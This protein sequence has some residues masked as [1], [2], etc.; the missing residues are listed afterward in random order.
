MATLTITW[1]KDR[2]YVS[3]KGRTITV[4]FSSSESIDILTAP[5][6]PVVDG[7]RVES[8]FHLQKRTGEDPN[9]EWEDVYPSLENKWKFKIKARS[10]NT[11]GYILAS[12][13]D[14]S[15]T[16]YKGTYRFIFKENIF[17]ADQGPSGD[18]ISQS[19][20]LIGRA[21]ALDK[22][23]YMTGL[24]NNTI[25][26]LNRYSGE[27]ERL[28]N[29]TD[30]KSDNDETPGQIFPQDLQLIDTVDGSEQGIFMLG[31]CPPGLF[32][33][34]YLE[35]SGVRGKANRIKN[36]PSNFG[37]DIDPSD[38]NVIK[39]FTTSES[40]I[41]IAVYDTLYILDPD[42]M[43]AQEYSTLFSPTNA[44]AYGSFDQFSE[45]RLWNL[46]Q[47]LLTLVDLET[48]LLEFN[49]IK[50]KNLRNVDDM[51]FFQNRLY[52]LKSAEGLYEIKW[53][54]NTEKLINDFY[55]KIVT[56]E[57]ED[58]KEERDVRGMATDGEFLY[59]VGGRTKA[60]YRID[61]EDNSDNFG[62]AIKI[63]DL[64]LEK[65]GESKVG[66]IF[67]FQNNLYL[68][69]L[70][71]GKIFRV[72]I[73][74]GNLIQTESLGFGGTNIVLSGLTE[75]NGQLYACG[76]AG[77]IASIFEIDKLT[78]IAT[79]KIGTSDLTFSRDFGPVKE[80]FPTALAYAP[81]AIE[82]PSRC[83]MTG[84][85]PG[86]RIREAALYTVNLS[87]G[88]ATRVGSE[89]IVNFGVREFSP[90][91]LAFVP[92]DTSLL[93]GDLYMVGGATSK[94]YTIDINPES[95][96]YGTAK[97]VNNTISGF[98]VGEFSPQGL[99]Y[100]ENK[101]RVSFGS[102]EE[103]SGSIA[104]DRV[105]GK[106]EPVV[107]KSPFFLDIT[108]SSDI[109]ESDFGGD[110]ITFSPS[111]GHSAE[112]E[113]VGTEGTF[114]Q[115][116]I[117]IDLGWWDKDLK[118]G[119]GN[120]SILI[121]LPSLKGKGE[122]TKSPQIA[123]RIQ[124]DLDCPTYDNDSWEIYTDK[125]QWEKIAGQQNIL[126]PSLVRVKLKNSINTP[127]IED[128]FTEKVVGG[129]Q[130]KNSYNILS[131]VAV[132]DGVNEKWIRLKAELPSGEIG[133]MRIGTK[134]DTSVNSRGVLGPVLG[135]F[136]PYFAFDTT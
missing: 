58:E 48:G 57:G 74:T 94:L 50:V 109:D 130:T 84:T 19:F 120:G 23:L 117:R 111:D 92:N 30:F 100:V 22:S 131:V 20:N 80:K 73:E 122:L 105:Y 82:A 53:D 127:S 61:L 97:V 77:D 112:V 38:R 11:E 15:N 12:P 47:G 40:T 3:Q 89:S 76:L 28:S 98:G 115:F 18:I 9:F 14:E 10:G 135:T 121:I 88:V 66:K 26:S 42:S 29:V 16:G 126:S 114:Y 59:V 132:E 93:G 83:F 46:S 24:S 35:Q 103:F 113:N 90:A 72:N 2:S 27:A 56:R 37:L 104:P 95:E 4:F 78:G 70:M 128:F 62:K 106:I 124:I 1:D 63:T 17:G 5:D 32:S 33:V 69:G 134:S 75:Q 7:E 107:R 51:V 87:N 49:N 96:K 136:S 101:T 116:R 13:E 52:A 39:A 65:V 36:S 21:E 85:R 81:A 110:T 129:I 123:K 25:Y 86:N 64:Q 43:V 102:R 108:W 6:D 55:L 91:G 31:A 45:E 8:S 68:H 41:W 44:L 34:K 54:G 119:S 60:L 79:R 133:S 71:T 67:Y 118:K 125:E 99:A